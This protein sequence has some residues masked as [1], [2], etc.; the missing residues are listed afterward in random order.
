MLKS[1]EQYEMMNLADALERRYFSNGDCVIKQG[2]T[3]DAFYIVEEGSVQ[4]TKEDPVSIIAMASIIISCT[5]VLSCL[6]YDSV[7]FHLLILYTQNNPGNMV[8]LSTCTKGQYFGGEG[9]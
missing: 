1:L 8:D 4:I 9:S 6:L 2:D 3:A 5:F 7:Y